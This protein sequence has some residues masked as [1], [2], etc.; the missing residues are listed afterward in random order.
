MTRPNWDK[1]FMQMAEL[2]STRAA[3]VRRKVGAVIVK[4]NQVLST[5]YNGPPSGIV[6][7]ITQDFFDRA[8]QLDEM[9]ME[10]NVIQF[11]NWPLCRLNLCSDL[12]KEFKEKYGFYSKINPLD[13]SNICLRE[14]QNIPSGQRYELCKAAHAEFNAIC[15]A[16]KHGISVN[17]SIMYCTC[18]PCVICAKAIISSGINS[19]CYLGNFID[20]LSKELLQKSKVNLKRFEE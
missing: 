20:D 7:C 14:A 18:S 10:D 19:I 12:E 16:A 5:G 6:H 8:K 1:Y 4:D 3:C 15:Q 13:S 11:Q 17:N 9:D 2:A